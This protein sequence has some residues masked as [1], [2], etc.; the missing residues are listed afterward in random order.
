MI[1]LIFPPD[2]NRPFLLVEARV[3]C[4]F[5]D[6]SMAVSGFCG[7]KVLVSTGMA[8]SVICF[9]Q[10]H[11][12]VL[13]AVVLGR[14]FKITFFDSPL[15]L[16]EFLQEHRH[17]LE[18]RML[19]IVREIADTM[20]V[21]MQRRVGGCVVRVCVRVM[22]CVCVCAY[23]L[24]VSFIISTS[25]LVNSVDHRQPYSSLLSVRWPEQNCNG[26]CIVIVQWYI[27]DL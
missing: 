21:S 19:P 7:R 16:G 17:V 23:V 26:V 14:G 3:S 8:I 11:W 25:T 5:Y 10:S 9:A 12:A 6:G 27:H 15:P 18:A 2:E 13:P 1:L 20:Q 24:H 4:R 22:W